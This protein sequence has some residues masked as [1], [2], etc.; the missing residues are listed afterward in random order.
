MFRKEKWL[1]FSVYK[2]PQ[3]KNSC[4]RNICEFL[5]DKGCQETKNLF[6]FGDFNIDMSCKSNCLNDL[7][8][9]IGVKNMVYSPTCF[10]NRNGTTVDLLVTSVP[11][12]IQNVTVIDCELSDC[13]RMVLW[14]TKL[15]APVKTNRTIFKKVMY[16]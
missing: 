13:H 11:K 14:A 9:V 4:I 3:V 1:L 10:K 2:Q 15:K 5:V 6:I 16:Q 12:R 8:D 7:F